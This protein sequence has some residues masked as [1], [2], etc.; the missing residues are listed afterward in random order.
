MRSKACYLV[1]INFRA[2]K[3]WSWG[4]Y[5]LECCINS[6]LPWL[7]DNYW[8]AVPAQNVYWNGI[9][10]RSSTTPLEPLYIEESLKFKCN[11]TLSKNTLWSRIIHNDSPCMQV[12][13]HHKSSE[14]SRPSDI[15]AK[16]LVWR[17]R[18]Q[19]LAL[20]PR[21]GTLIIADSCWGTVL[22]CSENHVILASAVWSQ[23]T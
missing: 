11:R 2:G 1:E 22:L 7:Q 14:K 3:I 21:P 18:P 4:K 12:I 9:P 19:N 17:P 6:V 15:K 20:R 16:D 5:L 8:N 23:H 13:M 10:V